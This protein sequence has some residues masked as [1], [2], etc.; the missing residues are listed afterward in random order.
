[1][2]S[3]RIERFLRFETICR[4]KNIFGIE[5]KRVQSSAGSVS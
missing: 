3:T 4:G 1:M 2:G 5:K